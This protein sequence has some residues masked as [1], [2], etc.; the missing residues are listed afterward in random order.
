MHL[1][2]V[3]AVIDLTAGAGSWAL[4]AVERHVPYFGVVLTDIHQRELMA[5]LVSEVPMPVL[6]SPSAP[7]LLSSPLCPPPFLAF[8]PPSSSPAQVQNLLICPTSH[9]Y[10]EFLAP[11]KPPK[12]PRKPKAAKKKEEKPA[13]P[14]EDHESVPDSQSQPDP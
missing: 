5:R 4:A 11:A 7:L 2:N 14:G 1:A 13:P 10:M 6:F 3:T 9:L 12:Q 8:F